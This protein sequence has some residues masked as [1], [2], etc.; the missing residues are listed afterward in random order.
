M[1]GS[2]RAS[3]YGK[4]IAERMARDLAARGLV[5]V[6]GGA[7]GIDAAANKG[8]LAA[9]GR[10]I[11][12]LGCGIDVSYP[13]EH[14]KLFDQIAETG[15][16]MSEFPPGTMPEGWR[17]P[18]RNRII[19]ALALAT[20][21]V[22]APADSGALITARFAAEQGKDV[23]AVPGNVDDIRNEGCHA[24]IR[25][26]ATLIESADQVLAALGIETQAQARAQLTLDY[27]QLTDEERA[28]VE[29]VCLEPKHVDVLIQESGLPVPKVTGTLT[30]LEMKGLVRRVPGNAFVRAL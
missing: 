1:V 19:S 12:V 26:G 30:L 29:L 22:Q 13:S 7:R 27:S 18:S 2:R 5:I 3:I 23:F 14:K 16:V 6:S 25:D 15:V 24:L 10:T 11:A 17:F 4:S 8:A 9:G 21:V 28:L 20:I